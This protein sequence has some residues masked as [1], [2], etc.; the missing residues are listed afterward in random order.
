MLVHTQLVGGP[1]A[2]WQ[3]A[4]D[5]RAGARVT[6]LP[7]GRENPSARMRSRRKAPRVA[8]A[9]RAGGRRIR[10]PPAGHAHPDPVRLRAAV[11]SSAAAGHCPA[12]VTTAARWSVTRRPR[13]PPGSA[14]SR[15]SPVPGHD[16]G[17]SRRRIRA[18]AAVPRRCQQRR[19]GRPESDRAPPC[20]R[21]RGPA[22]PRRAGWPVARP[23]RRRVPP[24]GARYPREGPVSRLLPR[25]RGR[26]QVVPVSER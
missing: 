16:R 7:A 25:S 8:A 21:W 2:V 4:A 17:P 15:T 20:M 9:H 19:S 10:R 1:P 23:C 14:R 13:Q 18:V 22:R 11:R 5:H 24:A 3:P 26:P 12:R 6:R